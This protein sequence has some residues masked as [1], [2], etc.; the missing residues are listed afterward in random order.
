MVEKLTALN[1]A[2]VKE[3]CEV[4]VKG[5]MLLGHR[6]NNTMSAVDGAQAVKIIQDQ[7]TRHAIMTDR[8]PVT[9]RHV[10]SAAA[11]AVAVHTSV[12]G[13]DSSET[14]RAGL[15]LPQT[16]LAARQPAS[17]RP[18]WVPPG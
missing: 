3:E 16:H 2:F 15:V 10:A 1:R 13:V 14:T 5:P 7:V 8:E 12:H 9:Y 11:V 18:S 6:T 17:F 4:E